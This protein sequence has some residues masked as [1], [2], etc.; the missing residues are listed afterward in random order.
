MCPSGFIGVHVSNHSLDIEKTRQALKSHILQYVYRK[1]D[2]P[3]RLSS[4]ALSAEYFD[5]KQVTLFP[6]RVHL[7]AQ[8]ILEAADLRNIDAVGGMSVG[9][10]P[11]VTAVSLVAYLEKN[12]KIPAFFVRK[13]VKEHG[14][15]KQIEGIELRKGMRVLIV[16]DVITQGTATLKAI[17]AVEK[18]GARVAKVICMID[19]EAGGSEII[20]SKYDFHAI[21]KKS[22]LTE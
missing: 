6:E 19:R 3:V 5:G 8:L 22:E 18:A 1:L 13:E 7:L 17:E 20:A 16:E 12:L 9:A 2:K 11:I 14:L 21:F 4:G 10:D 15:S